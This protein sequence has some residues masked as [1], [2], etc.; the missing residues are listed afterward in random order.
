MRSLA[1]SEG[2]ASSTAGSDTARLELAARRFGLLSAGT[3]VVRLG[4][5]SHGFKAVGSGGYATW[6][7]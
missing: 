5:L 6:S 2:Q 4:E 1:V 3:R 7:T